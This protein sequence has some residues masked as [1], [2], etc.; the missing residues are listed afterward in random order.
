[1][2]VTLFALLFLSLSFLVNAAPNCNAGLVDGTYYCFDNSIPYRMIIEGE[3][4]EIIAS[5]WGCEHDMT[6]SYSIRGRDITLSY[7]DIEQ[8]PRFPTYLSES[9]YNVVFN[10]GCVGFNGV[11][12]EDE[13]RVVC[14]LEAN[15]F[16]ATIEESSSSVL[17]PIVMFSMAIIVALI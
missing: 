2:K 7:S 10:E 11:Q 3:H 1:M 17:Y 13:H 5:A 15:Y 9:N 8:C 12:L 6:G 14:T 16:Y 4:F